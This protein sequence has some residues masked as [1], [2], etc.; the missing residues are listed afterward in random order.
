MNRNLSRLSMASDKLSRQRPFNSPLLLCA[1][2][3]IRATTTYLVDR[4]RLA[5][6]TK[7]SY[8]CLALAAPSKRTRLRL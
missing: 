7:G 2:A 5:R 4:T 6:L 8:G 1:A 3:T